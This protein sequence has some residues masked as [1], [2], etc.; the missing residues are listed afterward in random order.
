M[1][2]KKKVEGNSAIGLVHAD[3]NKGRKK[4]KQK[5]VNKYT[6]YTSVHA[7]LCLEISIFRFNI[8]VNRLRNGK[9]W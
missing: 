2:R 8:F 7:C 4:T 9:N 3:T 5:Y 1:K 6:Y